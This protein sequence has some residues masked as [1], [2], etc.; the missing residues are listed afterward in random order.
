MNT[1]KNYL[2]YYNPQLNKNM[3]KNGGDTLQDIIDYT[4]EFID[5]LNENPEAAPDDLDIERVR[6]YFRNKLREICS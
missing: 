4:N 1:Y 3:K 2:N 5:Y 6:N